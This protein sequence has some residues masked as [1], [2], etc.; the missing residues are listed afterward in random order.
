VRCPL[1]VRPGPRPSTFHEDEARALEERLGP[2]PSGA[3]RTLFSHLPLVA[4]APNG[5]VLLHAAPSARLTSL[6]QLEAVTLEGYSDW[7]SPASTRT[8]SP[9]GTAS[10]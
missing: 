8:S 10:S 9:C 7:T 2:G 6:E 4:V 3:L 5:V 1:N